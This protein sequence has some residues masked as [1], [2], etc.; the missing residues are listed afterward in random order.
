MFAEI[1]NRCLDVVPKESLMKINHFANLQTLK[2]AAVSTLAIGAATIGAAPAQAAIVN[3]SVSFNDGALNVS[4]TLPAVPGPGSFTATFNNVGAAIVSANSGSLGGLLP[5]GARSVAASSVGLSYSA[6]ANYIT[7]NDLIFDFG[8]AAGKLT[9]ATGAL[10]LDTPNLAG[11]HSNF[12]YQGNAA[13]F[14]NGTDVTAL[15]VTSFNFDVDNL[16][17]SNPA[18][19]SPNGSY[20]LVTTVAPTT[21]VPEPFTIVGTIIG[22]TAAFRM[23]KK[24]S[25][26][27]KK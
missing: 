27:V 23:R 7:T 25:D 12:T 2:I 3:G 21:A 15:N 4:G 14:T 8:A 11:S 20:S 10:F 1:E 5:L 26:S 24:V 6:G 19:T 18:N 13:T 22:G 9:I 17:A 16:A